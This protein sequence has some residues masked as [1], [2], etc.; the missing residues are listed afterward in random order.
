MLGSGDV[1]VVATA[2]A[3]LLDGGW[4]VPLPGVGATAARWRSFAAL[5][6]ALREEHR[7]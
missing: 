7:T 5:G 1:E 6:A 3:D 2:F 4:G